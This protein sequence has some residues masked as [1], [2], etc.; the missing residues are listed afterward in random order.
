MRTLVVAVVAAATLSAAAFAA[1]PV[2]QT[3]VRGLMSVLHQ[4]RHRAASQGVM[5]RGGGSV[6]EDDGGIEDD[7]DV[8]MPALKPTGSEA[9]AHR[10]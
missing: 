10:R 1:E 6:A 7:P 4:A 2:G 3:D 9:L 5:W 8:G